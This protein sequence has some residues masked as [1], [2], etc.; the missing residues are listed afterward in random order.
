MKAK[1]EKVMSVEKF[2]QAG[3]SLVSDEPA[4]LSWYAFKINEETYAIFDTFA[5]N[6]GRNAHLTGNVAS[7]IQKINILYSK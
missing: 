4:T 7:A 5:D 2:L 1:E 6:D 3:K